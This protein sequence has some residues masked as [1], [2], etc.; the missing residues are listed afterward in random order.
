M[1]EGRKVGSEGRRVEEREGG[2]EG[3]REREGWRHAR[4][5][6]THARHARAEGTGCAGHT[7]WGS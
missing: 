2:M 5:S 7:E 6:R 1:E 4:A 3:G